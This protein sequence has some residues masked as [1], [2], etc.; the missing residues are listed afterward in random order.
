M[1]DRIKQPL[2]TKHGLPCEPRNSI[3]TAFL[4]KGSRPKSYLAYP[5]FLMSMEL[6]YILLLDRSLL[7]AKGGDYVDDEGRAYV[8]YDLQSLARD[9]GKSRT[10]VKT[11]LRD[12][13]NADLILRVQQSGLRR[14]IYVK[15]CIGQRTGSEFSPT[16]GSE[17]SPTTGSEFSP[18]TGSGYSPTTGSENRPTTGSEFR[19]GPGQKTDRGWVGISPYHTNIYN[20]PNRNNLNNTNNIRRKNNMNM[21]F[22]YAYGRDY[23]YEEGESL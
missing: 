19:P 15:T 5:K 6:I 16:T 20:K 9:S 23:S 18:T 11:A 17:F 2:P 22:D 7:S 14:P 3:T 1:E 4:T 8:Y 10:V 13:E 21:A 12:L